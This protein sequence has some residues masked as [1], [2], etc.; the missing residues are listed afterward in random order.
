M[1]TDWPQIARHDP[2][3]LGHGWIQGPK[4]ESEDRRPKTVEETRARGP[5]R[6]P[7]AENRKPRS[8]S[9]ADSRQARPENRRTKTE[10]RKNENK[11]LT[12]SWPVSDPFLTCFCPVSDFPI[13]LAQIFRSAWIWKAP[14]LEWSKKCQKCFKVKYSEHKLQW[15]PFSSNTTVFGSLPS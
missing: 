11:N 3:S 7:R 4:T 8:E 6:K 14:T 1:L 13:Q 12:R 15:C 2:E 9:Q 5:L 10:N